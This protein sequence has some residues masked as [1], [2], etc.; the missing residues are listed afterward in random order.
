MSIF[1]RTLAAVLFLAAL[2]TALLAQTPVVGCTKDKSHYSCDKAQFTT[3]LKAAKVLAVE[4]HP[5]NKVSAGAL[6]GLARELGKRIDPGSADL[7]FELEP[8]EPDGIYFGPNDKELALL[9]V[10]QRGPNGGH[11]Q[12]LWVESFD[13]Q[14]DIVWPMVVRGAVRQFKEDFK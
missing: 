12:L 11:G 5:L 10:F 4:T 13:G 3:I 8:A 2:K 9:R 14:P 7:F 1:V 6:N